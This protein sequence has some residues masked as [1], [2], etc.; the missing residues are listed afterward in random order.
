MIEVAVSSLTRDLAVKAPLYAAAA[1]AEYW[2]LTSTGSAS[3]AT[4]TRAPRA[5]RT[6]SRC[7]P[8]VS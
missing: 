1:I 2:V 3:S 8:A 4:V 6:A 7:L 5:T